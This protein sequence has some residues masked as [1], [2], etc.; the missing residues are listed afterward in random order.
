M[1]KSTP[2]SGLLD[3][4]NSFLELFT[5]PLF[6]VPLYPFPFINLQIPPAFVLYIYGRVC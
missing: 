2:L 1:N 6:H 5:D 3:L 4:V